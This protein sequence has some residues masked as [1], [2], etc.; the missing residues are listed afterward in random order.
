[1]RSLASWFSQFRLTRRDLIVKKTGRR[2]GRA[3]ITLGEACRLCAYFAGVLVKGWH[4]RLTRPSGLAVWFAPHRPGP[5]YVLWSAMTL[6]GVRFARKPQAAN[7]TFYFDD[8]IIGEPPP[9][10]G[11]IQLNTGCADMSKSRVADVFAENVRL[12]ARARSVDPSRRGRREKRMQW[13]A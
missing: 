5:W 6:S 10:A 8:V 2:I 12:P 4:L 13:P 3:E 7:A 11:R 1:M 9:C